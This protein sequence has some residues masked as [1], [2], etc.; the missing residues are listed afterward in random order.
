[1]KNLFWT[2]LWG[3]CEVEQL[4]HKRTC[5]ESYLSLAIDV[6]K[7]TTACWWYL[8]TARMRTAHYAMQD[9]IYM[10]LMVSKIHPQ[11]QSE[12]SSDW[13]KKRSNSLIYDCSPLHLPVKY[14][15]KCSLS[16]MSLVNITSS[17]LWLKCFCAEWR[18]SY[19]PKNGSR[20]QPIGRS[21]FFYCN[22]GL[23]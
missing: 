21:I 20:E 13:L 4:G 11:L 5:S 6:G 23:V 12:V 17:F 15:S 3:I 1:M 2:I 10:N 18:N 19:L 9:I 7:G 8:G 16:V 14:L 22:V